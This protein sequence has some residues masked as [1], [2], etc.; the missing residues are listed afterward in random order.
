MAKQVPDYLA[1]TNVHE[2]DSYVQFDEGPHIYTVNGDSSST[3]VTTWIHSH[4]EKFDADK[5]LTN[6]FRGRKMRD[7]NYKYYGM[8]KEEIKT[9]WSSSDA[10]QKGTDMH[11]DI[12]CFYNGW[13]VKN[14]SLEYKHFLKF[15]ED[16]KNLKAYRTEWV[17]YYEEMNLA[18]SIDMVFEDENG[19]LWIYD[20]KRTNKELNPESFGN[21]KSTTPC[22][23]HLPDC[24]F[25]HYSLQLNIYRGILERKYGK[26]IKGMCLVRCHPD[27]VY[28][29]YDRIEVPFLDKEVNDL[30][31]F[32]L[33]TLQNKV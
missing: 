5:I 33:Q 6:M 32:R 4:F 10:A 13:D 19:D 18:G 28:N 29:T 8:T 31:E 22:I 3:S 11:Y 20:W 24:D 16:Y 25:W 2:R 9:L 21:K 26:K 27:N 17:V 7:P 14:D 30:F 12:E 23:S 1:K 15:A